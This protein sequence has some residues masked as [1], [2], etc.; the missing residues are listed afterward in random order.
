[1][2]RLYEVATFL[3]NSRGYLVVSLVTGGYQCGQVVKEL[4]N[5]AVEH[6]LRVMAETDQADWKEQ[7]DLASR[8]FPPEFKKGFYI[9]VA[10]ESRTKQQCRYW[11]LSTD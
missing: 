4:W 5:V 8:H 2:D 7:Q 1:M 11:R 9:Y 6:P 3:I 10:P